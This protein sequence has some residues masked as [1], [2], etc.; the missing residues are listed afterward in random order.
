M[1]KMSADNLELDTEDLN[2]GIEM[3]KL[4]DGNGNHTIPDN[5]QTDC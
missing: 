3:F 4:R 1:D 5:W 2:H